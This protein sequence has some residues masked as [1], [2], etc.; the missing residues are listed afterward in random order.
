[1]TPFYICHCAVFTSGSGV[2]QFSDELTTFLK[3]QEFEIDSLQLTEQ[4]NIAGTSDAESLFMTD[5]TYCLSITYFTFLCPSETA[6]N[7]N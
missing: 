6:I 5:M 3:K 1:M 2:I 4:T 7:G